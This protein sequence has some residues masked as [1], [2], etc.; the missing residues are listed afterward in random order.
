MYNSIARLRL[1]GR[2]KEGLAELK[3]RLKERTSLALL[4]QLAIALGIA[5]SRLILY[6]P[7]VGFEKYLPLPLQLWSQRPVES[8]ATRGTSASSSFLASFCPPPR[9]G[10]LE[11][12]LVTPVPPQADLPG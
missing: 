10:L 2:R 6:I 7:L 9:K 3:Q 11:E 8:I 4:T 12:Q 1:A 5:L